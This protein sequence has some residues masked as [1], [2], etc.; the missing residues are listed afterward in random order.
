VGGVF[1]VILTILIV[2]L[3]T[4]SG[5]R[6]IQQGKGLLPIYAFVTVF[7]FSAFSIIIRVK[8]DLLTLP[9]YLMPIYSAIP[10]GVL[11][12]F[13]VTH[14]RVW[15]RPVIMAALVAVN[16]NSDLT[17]KAI[18]M[19]Y[20]LL[21]WLKNRDGNQY[22]YTDYW[23]GYWLAFESSEKIIPAVIDDQNQEGFNRYRPY[24]QRVEESDNPL[25]I[26]IAENPSEIDFKDY[27]SRN[28]ITYQVTSID[29]YTIFSD[30]S[31]RI[32]YP[33]INR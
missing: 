26:Y 5:V 22:I 10:L 19:P 17:I 29:G 24:V 13:N 23:T 3:I 14:K 28:G 16:L 20:D 32:T 30:L 4:W 1:V 27:L 31:R 11:A 9:R 8:F 21:D 6:L 18:S 25:Y 15:L 33:L 7:V 12:L 2:L